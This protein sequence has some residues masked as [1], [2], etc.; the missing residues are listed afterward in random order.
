MT[1]RLKLTR[2]WIEHLQTIP[3]SGMGYQIV[4]IA[5]RDG[6]LLKK[7]LV[8]NSEEIELT[9]GNDSLH[10]KDIVSIELHWD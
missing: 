9:I 8:L 5:L 3:E 7:I 4:D 2:K 10:L 1:R 6:R